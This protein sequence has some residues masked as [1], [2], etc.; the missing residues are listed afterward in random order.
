MYR[1][2]NTC[3]KK[4]TSVIYKIKKT[5]LSK[6]N[7]AYNGN[8]RKPVVKVVN[9][10]GKDLVKGTDYTV[11]IRNSKNKVV[12]KPTNVGKYKVTV[13]FK[14]KYKDSVNK[15]YKIIPKATA[16]KSLK[17]GD[18]RFTVKW[19]KR[20]KQVDGYQVRY[21]TSPK[22]KSYIQKLVKG[23]NVTSKT[24]KKLKNKKTYYVKVRT[25]K[26]VNGT[27]YFSN[28]SKVKKIKTK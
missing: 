23:K 15:Y 9:S 7:I 1:I 22:F 5:S 13:N 17:A 8:A 19:N 10:K 6:Q 11:K 26:T 2:C 24:Y 4:S 20:T 16:I 3:D 12:T 18:N 27:K 21:S 28:W 25:Y 14:G